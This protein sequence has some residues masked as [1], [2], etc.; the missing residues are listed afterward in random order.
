M[1][2]DVLEVVGIAASVVVAVS[3]MMSSIV[4]LRWYNLIGAIMFTVY[5][6]LINALPVALVNGFITIIDIYYLYKM[7]SEKEQ[8]KLFSVSNGDSY[9]NDFKG[10]YQAEITKFFPKQSQNPE[11]VNFFIHR[12]LKI[13]G[14]L[15]GVKNNDVFVVSIDFVIPEFRDLKVGKFVYHESKN[16]F[17]SQG[18]KQIVCEPQTDSH[19]TYLKKVGFEKTEKYYK[20]VL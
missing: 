12:N 11:E 18:I 17:E 6:L 3:L 13:A 15:S 5:G 7:Y 20:F 9:L 4:K 2:I 16:F 10:F 14:V 1:N 19:E 8:F